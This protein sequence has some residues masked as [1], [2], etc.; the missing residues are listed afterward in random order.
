MGSA[1]CPSKAPDPVRYTNLDPIEE[2]DDEVN[3][4]QHNMARFT[5]H[6]Y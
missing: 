2:V 5:L 1:V 4:A 3:D 6:S